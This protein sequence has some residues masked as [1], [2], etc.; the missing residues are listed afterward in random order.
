MTLEH[1]ALCVSVGDV[2]APIAMHIY[3]AI[4][5]LPW[6]GGMRFDGFGCNREKVN[7]RLVLCLLWIV[8][9]GLGYVCCQEVDMSMMMITV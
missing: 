9:L 8:G 6:W 7:T 3:Q 1:F 2:I 4:N 5:M